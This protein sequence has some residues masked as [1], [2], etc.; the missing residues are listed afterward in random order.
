MC[1]EKPYLKLS[2]ENQYLELSIGSITNNKMGQK[3][4]CEIVFNEVVSE[5]HDEIMYKIPINTT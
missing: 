4:T 1:H 2:A 5:K 3:E